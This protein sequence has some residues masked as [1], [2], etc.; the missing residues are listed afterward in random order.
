MYPLPQETAGAREILALMQ[1]L[2][3]L[4]EEA[5]ANFASSQNTQTDPYRGLHLDAEDMRS[6]MSSAPGDP[7]IS[8]KTVPLTSVIHLASDSPLAWLQ[9]TFDLREFDLDVIVIALASEVDLRYERF[10]AYLQDDVTRKRPTVDLALNLL[11][12]DV[13]EKWRRR[14]HFSPA[15]PLIRYGLL[16]LV[17]DPY[18]TQ[19]P[20][21]SHFLK[22]DEQVTRF[23]LE[24][25]GLDEE[26]A[27]FCQLISTQTN[28]EEIPLLPKIKQGLQKLALQTISQKQPLYL[29]FRGDCDTGQHLAAAIATFTNRPLLVANFSQISENKWEFNKQIQRLRREAGFQWAVLYLE[30]IDTLSPERQ[31]FI[32]SQLFTNLLPSSDIVILTGQLPW[33]S[34]PQYSP[35]VIDII[36]VALEIPDFSHRRAYWQSQL[37]Q[38]K[39][40]IASPMLDEL[41]ERFYLTFPQIKRA[42]ATSSSQARWYSATGERQEVTIHDLF[43]A[44]RSQSGHDLATLTRKIQPRQ[45]W[46]DLV[47]P[48]KQQ[49]QLQAICHQVKYR[50]LV[51][52]EWGFARKLS[53]GKGLSVLFSGPPGTGKTMAA[54]AIANQLQLDLYKID[55]SQVVSKYIGETEKNLDRIFTAAENANAIL[56]FDEADAIFGK[57]AEVKDARDRYANL[58]VA[59]LLQK[60][61]EYT[62][63]SILTSNIRQNMDEA[64]TRRIRFIVTFPIPDEAARL[65]IWQGI[66]P[67]QM[68]LAEDMNLPLLAKQF[69][70]TGGSIRNVALAAAFLAAAEEQTVNMAHILPALRQEFQKMGQLIDEA[71]FLPFTIVRSNSHDSPG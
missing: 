6:L 68:P 67:Q 57:R 64:F 28:L 33:T 1:R 25:P 18:Q 41:A 34:L 2:D 4:L 24:Q 35:E 26:L 27:S 3:R 42:I 56:L 46:F 8:T 16:R 32:Q 11:C 13:T 7:F 15:A 31:T 37:A 69:Q 66:F 53:L 21:L 5:N 55:L 39:I 38:A 29:Y 23:L 71:E 47:L 17:A 59:Y 19:A 65:Q 61:E 45:T 10:Y 14:I 20:Q 58:E 60:M 40:E 63:I 22:L 43:A 9:Q 48:P 36:E 70:I 50:R 12:A 44:T 30:N 49:Q 52:N 51:Y 62:G 54:E